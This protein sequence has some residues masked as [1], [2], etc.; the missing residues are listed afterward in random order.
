[1]F[2]DI[3][4]D[5][6]ARQKITKGV[7]IIAKAVKATLG[8]SGKNVLISNSFID[9]TVTKDGVSV[10]N[11]IELRDHLVNAA[12]QMIRSVASRTATDAGDG[13][14]TA[15]VLAEAIYLEGLKAVMAGDPPLKIKRGIEKAVDS[16]ID[17]LDTLRRLISDK[18][19][20]EQ[21]GTIASN[22]DSYIGNLLADAMEK[23]GKDGVISIEEGT[24]F[25]TSV[26]YVEGLQFDKGYISPYLFANNQGYKITLNDAYIF[27]HE[28]RI[29]SLNNWVNF[30]QI[31]ATERKPLIIVCSDMSDLALKTIAT[32]NHQR[33]FEVA[34]IKAPGFGQRRKDIL[35]DIAAMTGGHAILSE[36]KLDPADFKIEM[37]GHV[38]RAVISRDH[39]VLVGG[40]A[41][42]ERIK[43][44][45]LHIKD[46]LSETQSEFDREKLQERLA[47]LTG[48]VARIS[49]GGK[50][51]AE[52]KEKKDRIED[53][54]HAVRAAVD[55]GI[56]PGGGTALA[57][58]YQ[59]LKAME[60]DVDE[61]ELTGFKILRN[62]L[63]A[64]LK[65]IAQNAGLNGDIILNEVLKNEDVS[66]G[67]DALKE[68][69][70]NLF[71]FGIIDPMKVT[72][73]ALQNAASIANLL[74]TTDVMIVENP[75][76]SEEILKNI[77]SQGKM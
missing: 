29:D 75:Y 43:E 5:S 38:E 20:I 50:T 27:L 63:T 45:I 19:E 7:E 56:L 53:A 59:Y 8:P 17:Y 15:T 41:D 57:R 1:M 68:V 23:V 54:L 72:R 36:Y 77:N 31:F 11:A 51:E 25:K 49:V 9:P 58:A 21:T 61:F 71:D 16:T 65:Q 32:N 34:V 60:K 33:I 39:T 44:Q 2:K 74:L 52:V 24:D 47:K 12:V 70:G 22:N 66:F 30:L 37:C 26:S 13:T 28:E 3:I 69:Y 62:A 14:T 76:E 42:K 6:D 46:E 4:F 64:P 18:K 48:G 55:E 35:K 40:N 10:A 67:Y 73:C